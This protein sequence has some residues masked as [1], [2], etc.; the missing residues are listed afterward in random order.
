VNRLILKCVS[1]ADGQIELSP[2]QLPAVLGRSRRADIAIDDGLLSR[3][4]SEIRLNACGQ[5]ELCDLNSTNLT[6]VNE[7]EIAS[8]VLKTGDCILLGDTQILVEVIVPDGDLHEKT[9]RDL[10]MIPRDKTID[11]QR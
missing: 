7:V 9:T 10:T 8:H 4:H 6:I 2:T 1:F 3:K 5:F 11:D